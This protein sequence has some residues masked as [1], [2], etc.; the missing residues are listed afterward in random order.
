MQEDTKLKIQKT[1]NEQ[2]HQVEISV[3]LEQDLMERHKRRAARKIAKQAKIPG[4]RPGKAPYPVI[5]RNFGEE[6]IVDEALESVINDVYPEMLKEAEIEPY[7]PG[8]ITD[9]ESKEPPKFKLLIPLMPAVELAD[10]RA[11]RKD[12][13]FESA[14]DDEVNQV[15]MNIQIQQA[16]T[17]PVE[18]RPVESGDMVQ[19]TMTQTIKN[20]DEG[21][22]PVIGTD[23]PQ[24]VYVNSK[25][26]TKDT[27]PYK[28]FM[29]KLIGLN[30]G[31]EKKTTHTYNELDEGDELFGKKVEFK[32]KVDAISKA[33]LPE[34]NDE[35]AQTVN[36]EMETLDDL[37]E[38]IKEQ[39]E[40]Y[41]KQQ[42]EN[43][44]LTEVMDEIVDGSSVKY[45]TELFD[46]EAH[47]FVHQM[48]DQAARQG[49]EWEAYLKANVQTEESL[50][51][52]Q[53]PE[54]EKRIKRVLVLEEIAR[55]EDLRVENE[56]LQAKVMETMVQG[57]LMNYLQSLPKQQAD[58]ISQR[59]T[60]DSANQILNDKL[61]RRLID[62]ASGEIEKQKKALEDATDLEKLDAAAGGD[63]E[64]TEEEQEEESEE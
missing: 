28:G 6:A 60:M 37:K 14:S 53:K 12:Y 3:E 30:I 25:F 54:L 32:F 33:D 8:S 55:L 24:S 18:D 5:V 63:E 43:D 59:L 45:P 57:G 15:L 20:P 23:M 21:Q 58:E 17:E 26:D 11:V 2:E 51:E 49:M 13:G 40:G 52:E 9:I 46:A 56:E 39:V 31:D 29:K 10:Y 38:N 34:L 22:E 48:Q 47:S 62:I 36:P 41:R 35:F 27:M 7:G 42:Y 1:I 50:I 16:V 19:L 64:E 44:Y 4:F 61:M